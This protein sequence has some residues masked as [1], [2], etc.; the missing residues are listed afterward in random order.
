M[1]VQLNRA[2]SSRP[3]RSPTEIGSGESKVGFTK[4]DEGIVLSSIWDEPSTTR[5]VWV[6]MLAMADQDGMV[7]CSR[8]GLNRTANISQEDFDIAIS[9]LESPDP[10]SRSPEFE[11]RRVQRCDGGW[12]ILNH[13]KYRQWTPSMKPSAIRM[14]RKRIKD[15]GVTS[16]SLDVTSRQ[17]SASASASSSKL[18]KILKYLNERTGKHFSG[19]KEAIALINGRLG[20]GRTL[21]DFIRVI[22]IKAAKW[23]NDPKMRDFLRPSTLFRSGHFEEYLNEAPAR[24]TEAEVG[25]HD[26]KTEPDWNLII[27]KYREEW[28]AAK[29]DLTL[30]EYAKQKGQ[31]KPQL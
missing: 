9:C 17:V 6:T 29:S 1:N 22:D 24:I 27:G 15:K 4:L 7:M 11:G 5:V 20:E 26:K 2:R 30:L 13:A 21:D 10:D 8:S 25:Q 14:R 16:A 3:F 28:L 12:L 18:D 23:E 19:S 31:D